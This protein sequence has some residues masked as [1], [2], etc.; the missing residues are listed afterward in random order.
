[1]RKYDPLVE[2]RKLEELRTEFNRK[3]D[4]LVQ[5]YMED[6]MEDDYRDVLKVVCSVSKIEAIK[7]YYDWF[8]GSL[9]NAK[10]EVE[11]L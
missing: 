8:G 11:S 5:E 10:R 2:L 7:L 9:R 1:M 4:Q 3:R 6:H